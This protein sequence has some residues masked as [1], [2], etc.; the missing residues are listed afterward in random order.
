MQLIKS[1]L[2]NDFQKQIYFITLM[3]AECQED[4]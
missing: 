4:V 1:R 3:I 2:K